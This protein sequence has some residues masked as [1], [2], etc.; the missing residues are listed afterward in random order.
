MYIQ[1]IKGEFMTPKSDPDH[2]SIGKRIQHAR[3]KQKL[4]QEHLAEITE[5]SPSHISHIESG[6]TKVSLPSLIAIANALHTTVDNLL[7]DNIEI[8]YESFDKDFRVLLEDCSVREKGVIFQASV[9]VKKALK[10]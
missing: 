10:G 9:Q 3:K 1:H 5:L 7:H 2:R 4:T 8:S 6:K